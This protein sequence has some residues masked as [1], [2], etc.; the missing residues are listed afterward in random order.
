MRK[1][2]RTQFGTNVNADIAH[3]FRVTCTENGK[4]M[5]RV[6]EKLMI[7]YCEKPLILTEEDDAL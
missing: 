5:N 2:V 1:K 6:I 4:K 7:L 3:K